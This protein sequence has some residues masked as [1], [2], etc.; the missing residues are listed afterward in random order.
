MK[1]LGKDAKEELVHVDMRARLEQAGLVGF[2]NK[3]NLWPPTLAVSVCYVSCACLVW[4][5]C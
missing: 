1:F 2:V 4:L 3:P 5:C